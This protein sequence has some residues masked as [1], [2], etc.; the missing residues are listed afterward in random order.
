[1]WE[2]L[3]LFTSVTMPGFFGRAFFL[4]F[5]VTFFLVFLV[6]NF[7]EWQ[8]FRFNREQRINQ[9]FTEEKSE[10]QSRVDN[11]INYITYRR[12]EYI[13]NLKSSL[14]RSVESA[15][16]MAI[17]MWN[18]YHG[19]Y[20]EQ[21]V[22]EM[23]LTSLSAYIGPGMKGKLFVNTLDGKS[24]IFPGGAKN[25]GQNVNSF[26]DSLGNYVVRRELNLL[27][28]Q[29]SG[30]LEY[31]NPN[32]HQLDKISFVKRVDVLGWYIG[33]RVYPEDL[34]G[35]IQLSIVHK[36]SEQWKNTGEVIFIN[37]F[38]GTPVILDGMPYDGNMNLQTNAPADKISV[39]QQE[40]DLVKHSREGGFFQCRWHNQIRNTSDSIMVYVSSVPEWR[41]IVGGVA[42][43]T[44]AEQKAGVE[45][46]HLKREYFK[47][48]VTTL[49]VLTIFT[50]VFFIFLNFYY[51]R[52]YD[53]INWFI[54]YFQHP[55][56]NFIETGKI[57]FKEIRNLAEAANKMTNTRL[58]IED[59]LIYNQRALKHLFNVAPVPMVVV[60]DEDRI[61]M[62]NHAF[63][64]L[65]DYPQKEVTGKSLNS[66]ICK[67]GSQFIT[68]Q[69]F[70]QDGNSS[71]VER[72]LIR[73]TRTGEKL[74]VSAIFTLLNAN[75]NGNQVL[76]IYRNITHERLREEQLTSALHKAEESDKLKSA[77][78]ANMSH[79]IR[80][81]MN[82]IFGFSDLLSDSDLSDNEQQLYIK[83]IRKSGDTLLHLIDD[84]IDFSKIEAG[85]LPITMAPF[86]VNDS[87]M[88]LIEWYKK[89][90]LEEKQGNVVL[91][92]HTQLSDTLKLNSDV[93]RI[94]QI[95]SNLL[96]NA[97]KFTS[98]G[99][100]DISYQLEENQVVFKVED[101]GI[102]VEVKNQQLIF[103][104]FRQAEPAYNRS[105]GG[106]GLGLSICKGL[107]ELL[108]GE[109]GLKSEYGK[110]SVFYFTI[111][112]N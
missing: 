39:F 7:S 36:L 44:D 64:E 46:G 22:R 68:L 78:L 13:E 25:A 104:R 107:V 58:Q 48:I 83:Y 72:E 27:R 15:S 1:M 49:V 20:P 100:I 10:L 73:Y 55:K 90:V 8:R 56:G 76:Q 77:F 103:E 17:A 31:Y 101:S 110:G 50:L 109:I 38:D 108:G 51:R 87:L 61:E 94:R 19:V 92:F 16:N 14:S 86:P 41:W 9:I 28:H 99:Y 2:H 91:H 18:T 3:K 29:N 57:H 97:F 45:E 74:I 81:P 54:Q 112:L 12:E 6:Y 35:D 102:G 67:D 70:G 33:H 21:K 88:D 62:A 89:I 106:A 52:F 69:D 111:P 75:D 82:A 79:E 43:L 34:L 24:V 71:G 93:V 42:Y 105:F 66:L 4:T 84:I 95:L 80:T 63:E 98:S 32:N 40:L 60:V 96:S 5:L 53:D 65:F 37:K 85:Q 23:I 30:F 11:E 59:E 26:Q 47:T